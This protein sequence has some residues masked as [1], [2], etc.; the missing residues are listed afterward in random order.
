MKLE[1]VQI[2][3]DTRGNVASQ[4]SYGNRVLWLK[5]WTN[6]TCIFDSTAILP[7]VTD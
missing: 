7:S 1:A 2:Y 4:Y 5:A 6:F 3:V